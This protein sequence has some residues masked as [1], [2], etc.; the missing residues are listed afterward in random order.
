MQ[1]WE[2]KSRWS[3]ELWGTH[4]W[5]HA[6]PVPSAPVP[7]VPASATVLLWWPRTH[8]THSWPPH[9][10]PPPD[11]L[12]P[13]RTIT[14]FIFVPV[15][16][17]SGS[18]FQRGLR[19]IADISAAALVRSSAHTKFFLYLYR[20]RDLAS[21]ESRG[22]LWTGS[23]SCLKFTKELCHVLCCWALPGNLLSS[24]F[25][26]RSIIVKPSVQSAEKTDCSSTGTQL[27][28]FLG[29]SFLTFQFLIPAFLLTVFTIF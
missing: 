2:E 26:C 11:M 10:I 28:L 23:T 19:V 25:S 18:H 12:I 5:C 6:I 16:N 3:S 13:R 29:F 17:S 14:I 22:A 1:I 20:S 7:T 24:S 21:I 27:T 4:E 9:P 8:C 15:E